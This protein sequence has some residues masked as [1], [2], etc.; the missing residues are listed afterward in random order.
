VMPSTPGGRYFQN[1]VSSTL[2]EL[3]ARNAKS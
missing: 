2:D 1:I 3:S